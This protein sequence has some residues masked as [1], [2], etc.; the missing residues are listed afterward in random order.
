MFPPEEVCDIPRLFLIAAAT[1]FKNR[2]RI[3]SE[4]DRK[5][6]H[7]EVKH[8]I[9]FDVSLLCQ[10]KT[11]CRGFD[12]AIICITF[13]ISCEAATNDLLCWE[14]WLARASLHLCNSPLV[15][16]SQIWLRL[17]YFIELRRPCSYCRTCLD[18]LK[19]KI[20]P[21]VTSILCL[22]SILVSCKIWKI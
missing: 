9:T 7:Q 4:S 8:Q 21:I 17:Q 10:D 1:C 11:C 13:P 22:S 14:D 12:W 18:W 16:L 15:V 2:I 6:R 20:T 3:T 19:L 5:C